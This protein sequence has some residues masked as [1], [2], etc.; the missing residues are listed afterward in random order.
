MNCYKSEEQYNIK[1]RG[2]VFVVRNQVTQKREELSKS[3]L[4]KEVE[5]DGVLYKVKGV[6][7]HCV[8]IIIKGAPIGLMV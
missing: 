4:G 8:P 3:L 7:S 6:E 5:I 1:G 2:N